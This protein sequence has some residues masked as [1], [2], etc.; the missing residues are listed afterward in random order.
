MPRLPLQ[1]GAPHPSF[2]QGSLRLSGL[3][4]MRG[5]GPTSKT[6]GV[7]SLCAG[8]AWLRNTLHPDTAT[9][10][11]PCVLLAFRAMEASGFLL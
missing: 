2:L 6:L 10:L 5:H 7:G 11:Q 8:G 9:A 1:R 4:E 3:K